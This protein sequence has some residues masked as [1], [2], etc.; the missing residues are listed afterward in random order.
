MARY[1]VRVCTSTRKGHLGA[2]CGAALKKVPRAR[3]RR[4]RAGR[5]AGLVGATKPGRDPV[6]RT[7]NLRLS[8]RRE[9]TQSACVQTPHNLPYAGLARRGAGSENTADESGVSDR[10]HRPGCGDTDW[11][12]NVK[13]A[14]RNG[15]FRLT[16]G[17]VTAAPRRDSPTL[18]PDPRASRPGLVP[19]SRSP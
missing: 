13:T 1:V 15:R 5:C 17:A 18:E 14:P 10:G 16:S 7:L 6:A 4:C 8:P 12:K 3:A 2:P 19:W 11:M 9:M